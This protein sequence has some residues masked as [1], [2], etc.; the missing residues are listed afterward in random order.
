MKTLALPLPGRVTPTSLTFSGQ[1]PFA[2]Y[3]ETA[4]LL[5]KIGKGVQWW[6]GDLLN[7]GAERYGEKFAQAEAETGFDPGTLANL[8]S[9]CGRVEPS[10]RREHLSFGH[11]A[12]VAKL[13]PA[14]QHR[15]LKDAETKQWTRAE[16]RAALKGEAAAPACPPHHCRCG[17]SWEGV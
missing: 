14:E 17:A 2:R 15:W 3:L 12:E 13:D 11:H 7:Y 16:L 9:V 4:R 5:G 8:A 6:V 10:R 1:L